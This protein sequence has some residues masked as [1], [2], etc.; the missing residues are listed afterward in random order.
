MTRWERSCVR[1]A[2]WAR[3]LASTPL[4]AES[5]CFLETR[6]Q[7]GPPILGARYRY[8][9][10]L[11]TSSARCLRLCISRSFGRDDT[12]AE[13]PPLYQPE[14]WEGRYGRPSIVG[15][16]SDG[17]VLAGA[18]TPLVLASEPEAWTI[19]EQPRR[20]VRAEPGGEVL[21][22]FGEHPTTRWIRYNRGNRLEPGFV[23]QGFGY[24]PQPHWATRDTDLYLADGD[25]FEIRVYDA[26]ASLR[27]IIRK[28][29]APAAIP[30]T[31][32]DTVWDA[33][34]ETFSTEPEGAWIGRIARPPIP[35]H[36]PAIDRMLL[37]DLGN[38]WVRSNP[39]PYSAPPIW[40][41]F[42]EDGV[43]RHSLRT[44]IDPEHIGANHV[45]TV[46]RDEYNAASVAVFPLS[47]R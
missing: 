40:Y 28:T 37:D 42:D 45:V 38:V 39:P 23:W 32:T 14:L 10:L 20:L 13:T 43:L 25:R 12:E 26:A 7:C 44:D 24:L 46:L 33:A 1:S 29:H 6:S 15:L 30:R 36:A 47:K 9:I 4:S 41:V 3:D 2:E 31:W 11:E 5:L 18:S 16:F 17:T 35:E 27:R 22:D 21:S 19:S 8:S 34:V